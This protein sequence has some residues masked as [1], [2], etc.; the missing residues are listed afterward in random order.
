ESEICT[1][2]TTRERRRS[3]RQGSY[4]KGVARGGAAVR[5]DRHW[6]RF[7]PLIIRNCFSC[8]ERHANFA[9][10]AVLRV[11][12]RWLY[13]MPINCGGFTRTLLR[14]VRVLRGHSL[15][16]LSMPFQESSSWA[17]GPGE[18]SPAQ[19]TSTPLRTI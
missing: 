10:R 18:C 6:P 2:A 14:P 17:Q 4:P 3:P 16:R 15:G 19:D 9:P 1:L 7:A 12:R 5:G 11:F 13:V 8:F